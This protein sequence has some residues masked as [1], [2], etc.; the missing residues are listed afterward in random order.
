MNK[1]Y[2]GK[3]DRLAEH[4]NSLAREY[5]YSHHAVQQSSSETQNKRFKVL[6]EGFPGFR[7]KKILD[8]G[9]GSGHFYEFL[10]SVGFEGEYVG[11]D[12]SEQQIKVA[13]KTHPKARFELLNIFENPIEELFDLVFISGVFNNEKIGRAHV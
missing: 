6:L 11:Y 13:R 10:K 12:I 3:L 2:I 4:Y 1:E 5:G 9:C 8:F 7:N